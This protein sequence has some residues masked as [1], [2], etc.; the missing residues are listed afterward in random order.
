MSQRH[1]LN[2][3]IYEKPLIYQVA[4]AKMFLILHC[5]HDSL[6]KRIKRFTSKRKMSAQ[7]TNRESK[8]KSLPTRKSGREKENI[9]EKFD[10]RF[11]R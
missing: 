5:N 3:D 7:E 2:K 4:I 10:Q 8:G 9:A 11:A 6:M 1:P